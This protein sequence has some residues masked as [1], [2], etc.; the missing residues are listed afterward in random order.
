[1]TVIWHVDDHRVSYQ[2]AFEISKFSTYLSGMYS[3]KLTVYRGKV[4]DSLGMYLDHYE[5]GKVKLSM[6]KYLDK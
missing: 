2:D 4:H 6:I 5:E 1:M 3:N